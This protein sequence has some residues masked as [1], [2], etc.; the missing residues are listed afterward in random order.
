MKREEKKALKKALRFALL[1]EAFDIRLEALRV[2][3]RNGDIVRDDTLSTQEILKND[4]KT[5]VFAEELRTM[6]SK[7]A[8]NI[9]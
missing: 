4:E 8:Y 2:L 7:V 1:H 5:E 3:E 9:F 6:I